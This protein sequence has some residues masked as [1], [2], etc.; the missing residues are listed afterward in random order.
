MKAS[1]L[2]NILSAEI[3]NHGDLEV[4]CFANADVYPVL[5]VQFFEE[6]IELSCGY[7]S[8]NDDEG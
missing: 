8:L 3:E 6:T 1:E 2:V 4:V 7:V 5:A